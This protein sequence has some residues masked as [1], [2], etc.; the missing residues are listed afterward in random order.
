VSEKHHVQV[1]PLRVLGV[2][3][4]RGHTGVR[5][6]LVPKGDHLVQR[7]R[8]VANLTESL[9]QNAGKTLPVKGIGTNGTVCVDLID[10]SLRHLYKNRDYTLDI[11]TISTRVRA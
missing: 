5:N 10:Q 6:T 4:G 11:E 9:R 8:S 3:Y 2:W 7:W 1:C